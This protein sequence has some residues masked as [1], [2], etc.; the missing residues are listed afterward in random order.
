MDATVLRFGKYRDLEIDQVWERDPQYCKW[1]YP[2]EILI[3]EYP[4]IKE[5]LYNKLNGADL[6]YVMTWGKYKGKSISWIKK[7]NYGY[8]EWLLKNQ[9]VNEN[10]PKLKKELVELVASSRIVSE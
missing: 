2:Q 3:G 6:S 7:T 9:F 10:C 4:A 8:I 1:L 5:F